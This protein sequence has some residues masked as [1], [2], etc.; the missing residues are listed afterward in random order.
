MRGKSSLSADSMASAYRRTEASI[1]SRG[2]WLLTFSPSRE[3]SRTGRNL[4]LL[5]V[6]M[7]LQWLFMRVAM[8]LP[9]S[10]GAGLS[11][12][13]FSR[14]MEMPPADTMYLDASSGTAS[15]WM[16][17]PSSNFAMQLRQMAS[18]CA[19]LSFSKQTE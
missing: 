11:R 12:R 4:S 3:Y 7:S 1:F 8:V 14:T 9:T 2:I 17:S 18:R 15:S 13:R 16:R 10:S 6:P 19:V 5:S